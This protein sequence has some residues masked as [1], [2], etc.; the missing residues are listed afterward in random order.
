ML[1]GRQVRQPHAEVNY[2]PQSGTMKLATAPVKKTFH[3]KI[4][5]IFRFFFLPSSRMRK[6]GKRWRT[7]KTHIL[8][9]QSSTALGCL[10]HQWITVVINKVYIE[11]KRNCD[12]LSIGAK[13]KIPLFRL[14]KMK[15]LGFSVSQKRSGTP[16]ADGSFYI[17][18]HPKWR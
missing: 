14:A 9:V 6:I 17:S 1:S 16:V 13:T 10:Q 8:I 18:F 3:Y 11:T 12:K 5:I 4:F 2:I 7:W 15:I